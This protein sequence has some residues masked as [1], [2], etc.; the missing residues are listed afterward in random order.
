MATVIS[1][2]LL[3]CSTALNDSHLQEVLAGT[4][5]SQLSAGAVGLRLAASDSLHKLRDLLCHHL[6]THTHTEDVT[7]VQHVCFEETQSEFSFLL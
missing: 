6:L 3:C 1:T 7:Q 5:E 4:D 2:V